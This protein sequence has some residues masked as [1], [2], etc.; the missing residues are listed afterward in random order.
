MTFNV[1]DIADLDYDALQSKINF[2]AG[3]NDS[4][5]HINTRYDS[6]SEQNEIF[7]VTAVLPDNRGICKSTVTIIDAGE[8]IICKFIVL[9]IIWIYTCSGFKKHECQNVIPYSGFL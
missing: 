5:I 3:A 2:S 1:F 4:K 8:L 9:H 6:M 7:E